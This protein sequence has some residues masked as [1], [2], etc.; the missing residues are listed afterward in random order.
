MSPSP[1]LKNDNHIRPADGRGLYS[2]PK[3]LCAS[4]GGVANNTSIDPTTK[5]TRLAVSLQWHLRGSE[6]RLDGNFCQTP[7]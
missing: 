1:S 2:L 3:Q 5:L 7:S 6:G 4:V